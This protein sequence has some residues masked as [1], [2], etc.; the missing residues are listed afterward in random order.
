[1]SSNACSDCEHFRCYAGVRLFRA[2]QAM[3]PGFAAGGAQAAA[4]PG[5]AEELAAASGALPA[6]DP[7]LGPALVAGVPVE[8]AATTALGAAP[9]PEPDPSS[10]PVPCEPALPR[11][12]TRGRAPRGPPAGAP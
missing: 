4:A 7:C 10:D 3:L 8:M 11:R 9:D 1:M 5:P 6:G 2:L 12:V